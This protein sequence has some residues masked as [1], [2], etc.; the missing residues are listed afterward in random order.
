MLAYVPIVQS[1]APA[2]R[3]AGRSVPALQT[4]Q[5]PTR[6][7]PSVNRCLFF[8]QKADLPF[9]GLRR[10]HQL[11]DRCKQSLD[12]GIMRGEFSLQL[13]QLDHDLFLKC[14]GVTKPVERSDHV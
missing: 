13:V 7:A 11:S 12:I 2:W 3:R 5:V 8:D 10:R 9:I 1:L 14:D 4:V 6:L